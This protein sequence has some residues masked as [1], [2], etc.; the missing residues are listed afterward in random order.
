VRDVSEAQARREANQT[1][2][3]TQERERLAN[4]LLDS[5]IRR[6]FRTGLLHQSGGTAPDGEIT[7]ARPGAEEEASPG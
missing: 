7:L 4:E 3:Q 2:A 5:V 1:V 6:L